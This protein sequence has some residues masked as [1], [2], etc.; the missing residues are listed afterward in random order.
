MPIIGGLSV[1]V[2][3]LSQGFLVVSVFWGLM[4]RYLGYMVGL[5]A[6]TRSLVEDL[7]QEKGMDLSDWFIL[8]L[9][10]LVL[11]AEVIKH[12]PWKKELV[13]VTNVLAVNGFP[14]V[15]F[16]WAVFLVGFLEDLPQMAL[17][18]AFLIVIEEDDG[19]A[20]TG[21]MAS[22]TLSVADLM[23]KS[24]FPLLVKPYASHATHLTRLHAIKMGVE[25]K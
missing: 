11:D 24:I 17:Q 3:V 8:F 23:V 22:L 10:M 9:G 14:H 21:A 6:Q 18:V 25:M 19:W 4:S 13:D 15:Y 16:A 20:I 12:L 2:F 7:K 1:L 5:D